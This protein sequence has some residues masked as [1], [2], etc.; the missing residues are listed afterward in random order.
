MS[1]LGPRGEGERLCR[2]DGS[3]RSPDGELQRHLLDRL[4]R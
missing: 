4:L 2:M 3:A 1:L